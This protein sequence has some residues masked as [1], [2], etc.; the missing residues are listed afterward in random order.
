MGNFKMGWGVFIHT[1]ELALPNLDRPK[2]WG[3]GDGWGGD[4]VVI[5]WGLTYSTTLTVLVLVYRWC[6]GYRI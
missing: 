6:K 3:F 2:A 1:G 5:G 4:G